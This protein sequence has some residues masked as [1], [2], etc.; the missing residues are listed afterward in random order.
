MIYSLANSST[1]PALGFQSVTPDG[2]SLPGL[3]VGDANGFYGAMMKLCYK[4]GE[5]KPLS[6]FSN[7]KNAK[8]GKCGK[9][10]A[11]FI[12][13]A[14][15]YRDQ[16]AEMVRAKAMAYFSTPEGRAVNN[17]ATRKYKRANH[18]KRRAQNRANK[19]VRG[20]KLTKE[21]CAV[22]GVDKGM[23]M[24]HED[25]DKPLEVVFLCRRCHQTL[26]KNARRAAAAAAKGE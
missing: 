1:S 24:H 21:P 16:N 20:G 17:K 26:H 2:L 8:D 11:C 12:E 23:E 25:Y 22:C 15:Q 9:C 14:R 10:K 3:G 4:C 19:A 7:N 18:H 6:D 5:I 13:Y